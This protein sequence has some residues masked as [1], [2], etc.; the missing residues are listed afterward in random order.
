MLI[1]DLPFDC[2]ILI[3]E[4]LRGNDIINLRKTCSTFAEVVKYVRCPRSIVNY[5]KRRDLL[6]YGFTNCILSKY[7]RT[8]RLTH[9]NSITC[10]SNVKD[11]SYYNG[12]KNLIVEGE[13][14]N[15]GKVEIEN[16]EVRIEKFND[17]YKNFKSLKSLTISYDSNIKNIRYLP[18]LV[19]L[20]INNFSS[21]KVNIISDLPKLEELDVLF[22]TV[23][24][25][26]NLPELR[27]LRC[28]SLAKVNLDSMSKLEVLHYNVIDGHYSHIYNREFKY[29]K[30]LHVAGESKPIIPYIP[31]LERLN[32]NFTILKDLSAF[33]HIKEL[34]IVGTNVSDI[35]MLTNLE[36]LDISDTYVIYLPK[37]NRIHTLIA[38]NH[39]YHSLDDIDYVKYLNIRYSNISTLPD[40]NIITTLIASHTYLSSI[41]N[42][43]YLTD[44]DI[45]NTDITEIPVDNCIKSINISNTPI[46]SLENLEKAEIIIAKNTKITTLPD[47]KNIIKL[48]ISHTEVKVI[49]YYPTIKYLTIEY[50]DVECVNHLTSLVELNNIPITK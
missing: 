32:L 10:L 36:I 43:K 13:A 22:T 44:V 8:N 1:T 42:L 28:N 30:E 17:L 18:N 23:R 11:I 19:K 50:T 38:E 16:I 40:N 46:S 24:K 12:V 35:S 34:S 20:S 45:S 31:T 2:L 15:E 5:T 25:I 37:N 39:Q 26:H 9:C 27:V 47:L 6:H 7:I 33:T 49:P 41:S 4:L 14:S 3:F 21:S 48:N 29:L